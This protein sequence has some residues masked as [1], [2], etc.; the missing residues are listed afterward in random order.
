MKHTTTI[1]VMVALFFGLS[2]SIAF[3]Q[4]STAV[5]APSSTLSSPIS[6]LAFPGAFG[7]PS[8]VAPKSGSGFIGLTYASPRGGVAGSGGDGDLVVGY[9]VGNPIDAV[10]LTFGLAVTGLEPFGDAGSLSVSA[11]RLLNVG[12]RSATFIGASVSNLAAWGP[13]GKR[14]EQY[15]VYVSHLIGV[16]AAEREIPL[17]L[18]V[19]YGTDNTLASNGSGAVS[20]GLFLGAGFGLTQNLS[21]S[22]SATKTQLN[23]GVSYGFSGTAL[24]GTV[25]VNDVTSNTNRQQVTATLAYAF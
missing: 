10:S 18:V 21:G 3:A 4:T 15:S 16:M 24:S 19:G 9:S 25:G 14:P 11:S 1:P 2:G 8:A 20:D 7:V 12:D 17:Q 6:Q 23:A 5:Q 22:V 13:N